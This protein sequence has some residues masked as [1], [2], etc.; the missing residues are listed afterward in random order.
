MRAR[1]IHD[2]HLTFRILC[3]PS[4]RHLAVR[5]VALALHMALR[6]GVSLAHVYDNEIGIG[7]LQTFVQIP[8]VGLESIQ[9]V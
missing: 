9:P 2:K 5:D 8:T 6:E 4:G 3:H 1:A 7:Q